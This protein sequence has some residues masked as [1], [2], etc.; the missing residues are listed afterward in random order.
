MGIADEAEQTKAEWEWRVQSDAAPSA[1]GH[2]KVQ[3]WEGGPYWS[4][5]NIG[6]G[7][8]WEIGYYFWWGDAIGYKHIYSKNVWVASDGSSSDF[9][10]NENYTPTCDQNIAA[11]R[12][13]GWI[14]G[15]KSL[16]AGLFGLREDSILTPKYDAAQVQW[17]GG[18]RIPTMLEL[19]ELCLKCNWTWSKMNG[20]NGYVICGRGRYASSSIFLPCTGN[21]DWSSLYHED[22]EGWYW[23]SVPDQ[24]HDDYA[25][26]LGFYSGHHFVGSWYRYCGYAI[27][28]VQGFTK[29]QQG[30][31]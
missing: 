21:G 27:R 15:K 17:G 24:D 28:P 30:R 2:T 8:P 23:S 3:L 4:D 14:C 31:E 29:S 26:R 10:F 7:K 5:T 12:A 9:A 6:A 19:S 11:L 20:V 13:K 1:N 16:F 25:Y 22:W 18:W